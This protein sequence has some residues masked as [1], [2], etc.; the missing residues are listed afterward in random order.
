MILLTTD[1]IHVL[2][3]DDHYYNA[4]DAIIDYDYMLRYKRYC[5]QVMV[6]VRSRSTD[7]VD[8]AL[9]CVDG[10]SVTVVPLPDP[11]APIQGLMSLPRMVL[12]VLTTARKAN[13]YYLKMPDAMATMVKIT[14][15]T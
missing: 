2:A 4:S 13:C 14:A 5:D 12:R 15:P 6:L 11:Q 8:P 9:A 3:C 1:Q 10:D 7:Q